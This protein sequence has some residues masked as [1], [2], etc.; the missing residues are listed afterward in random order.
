MT[1]L[2]EAMGFIRWPLTLST[3]II[4]ALTAYSAMRLFRSPASAD[5]ITKTW[6]D[7]ILFWGGFAVVTGV[8]GTLVGIV[9]AAQSIEAAGAVSTILVWGG[10]KVALYSSVVGVLVLALASLAWFGLQIRWRYLLA[11]G[12]DVAH[13]A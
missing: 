1:S 11:G 5:P 7:A 9:V 2:W 12:A 6:L 4:V 3:L 13:T 8:L 10:I